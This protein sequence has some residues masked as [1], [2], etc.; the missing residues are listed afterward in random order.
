MA[1]EKVHDVFGVVRDALSAGP[2]RRNS[3]PWPALIVGVFLLASACLFAGGGRP[4]EGS[5]GLQQAG[6]AGAGNSPNQDQAAPATAEDFLKKGNEYARLNKWKE[7][8]EAYRKAVSL[9]SDYP[10]AHYNLGNAYLAQQR[11]AD[12]IREYQETLRL[13]PDFPGVHMNLG[14]VEESQG[15]IPEAE[16]EYRSEL[17]L[18]P[19]NP[20]AHVNLANALAASRQFNEAV[21]EFRKEI[22]RASC[23]ERVY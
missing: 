13:R 18:H 8:E 1:R 22:G 9:R 19:S 17:R 16:A 23:R 20:D 15:H 14:A 11:T 3:R 4:G 12:A 7:A 5:G 2:A 6:S 21:A 10:Q